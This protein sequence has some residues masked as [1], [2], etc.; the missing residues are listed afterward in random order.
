M[1]R[2]FRY[3]C[4]AVV[5]VA[6][7]AGGLTREAFAIK[8]FADEFKAMYVK[9]GT[10]LAAAVDE[11]KCNVCHLPASKKERN[12]YGHALAERLDKK[13]DAKNVEKI[14]K[15]LEEVAALS[16]DPSKPDAPTFGKLIEE[17]KL[18][19]GPVK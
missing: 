8:Q 5:G 17:G 18:P 2:D 11:A 4:L 3:S 7:A 13:E 19:G 12:A 14:K 1:I 9:E 6:L 16:S 10:P 15:A